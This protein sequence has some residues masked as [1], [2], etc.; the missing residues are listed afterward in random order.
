MSGRR[1]HWSIRVLREVASFS[2]GQAP[3]GK[4]TNSDGIGV[5][6]YRSGEFGTRRPDTRI[7]TTKPL[8][9]ASGSDV[10]V[11]VVGANCGDVN[12]G[13]DGA[14]GRSV[15][16]VT[17]GRDLDQTY[18]FHFL[19]TQ[20]HVLR[21]GSQGS[22]QGVITKKDLGEIDIPMPPLDEQ[23]RIVDILEAHLSRLEA[24]D[25]ALVAAARRLG[26]LRQGS[27]NQTV[28][29]ALSSAGTEKLTVADLARVGSGAT[30]LKSNSAYYGGGTIPWVTSGDLHD[31]L[32]TRPSQFIT[33]VALRETAVKLWPAGTLL[34]AM[35]GEG[36]TRGTVGELGFAA[37]T[38]QA[39]AAIALNHDFAHLRSWVR[40]FFEAN[41]WQLRR[42]AAGGVQPNLSLGRIKSLELPVPTH[43]TAATL[44]AADHELRESEVRLH[45]SIRTARKRAESLR[46]ALLRAAFSGRLIGRPSDIDKIEELADA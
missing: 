26:R 27:L 25:S 33:D 45:A 4:E 35:Y 37:T 43:P 30:P 31:G 5:P 42:Q 23:R 22:A 10:F 16:A 46:Q 39:C 41:Y 15:S 13:A 9:V 2:M 11:C 36:K 18:L 40:L 28:T 19:S 8:R 20:S 21:A 24:G 32:I 44:V 34:V 38:N 6:F 1:P 12:L 29:A 7:W 17:P 14:I 3:P